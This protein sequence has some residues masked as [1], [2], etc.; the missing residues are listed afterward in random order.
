MYV[1]YHL[2]DWSEIANDVGC[3]FV[4]VSCR[5]YFV[6]LNLYAVTVKVW[7]VGFRPIKNLLEMCWVAS[8]WMQAVIGSGVFSSVTLPTIAWVRCTYTHTHAT[9]FFYCFANSHLA[10]SSLSRYVTVNTVSNLETLIIM[11][12]VA[13]LTANDAKQLSTP[14]NCSEC[15]KRM[16]DEDRDKVCV[17][18]CEL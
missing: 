9:N 8:L 15:L 4:T 2:L 12:M 5:L 16:V 3:F 10:P 13:S 17:F 11:Q 1:V 14:V 18:L 7:K 6:F